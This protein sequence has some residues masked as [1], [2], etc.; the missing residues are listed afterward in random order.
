MTSKWHQRETK[1]QLAH[2]SFCHIFNTNT[3]SCQK[4]YYKKKFSIKFC[5]KNYYFKVVSFF[6][7]Q[8]LFYIHPLFFKLHKEF[9]L[10]VWLLAVPKA[11]I[12]CWWW[13]RWW[14]GT[15]L[16]ALPSGPWPKTK[17]VWP[18]VD[19]WG[20]N[21]GT[22]RKLFFSGRF[23]SSFLKAFSIFQYYGKVATN[24]M[25]PVLILNVKENI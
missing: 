17:E 14:W 16:V 4:S 2:F 24:T 5:K 10:A 23:R 25:I 13:L 18:I 20:K 21:Y 11:C 12:H 7:I 22:V 1:V 15:W 6:L 19:L 8:T 9:G 3:T